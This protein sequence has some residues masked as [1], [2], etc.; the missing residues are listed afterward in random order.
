MFPAA[1]SATPRQQRCKESGR[2][3]RRKARGKGREGQEEGGRE[4]LQGQAPSGRNPREASAAETR[5]PKERALF[6]FPLSFRHKMGTVGD[7]L[8]NPKSGMTQWFK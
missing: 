3:G 2:R 4:I 5:G 6:L 1:A 8:G 7:Y